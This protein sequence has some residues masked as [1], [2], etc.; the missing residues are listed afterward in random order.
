VQLDNGHL[1]WGCM[2]MA[3]EISN[4]SAIFAHL[5]RAF[6]IGNTGGLYDRRIVTHIVNHP[7]KAVIQHIEL[8][9]KDFLKTFNGRPA[10][11]EFL[12]SSFLN[13]LNVLVIT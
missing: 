2:K 7:N 3:H 11:L 1:K 10:R 4:Q 12:R 9:K 5:S 6:A 8:R 13:F